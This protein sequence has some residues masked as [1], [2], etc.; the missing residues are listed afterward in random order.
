MSEVLEGMSEVLEGM[1]EALVECA[2]GNEHYVHCIGVS[3]SRSSTLR[4]Q[5]QQCPS[6]SPRCHWS[7]QRQRNSSPGKTS[8]PT[9]C[10]TI[11]YSSKDQ[12]VGC[13]NSE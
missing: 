3:R 13:G 11:G 10:V 8:S 2:Q 7:C 12:G 1:S 5:K 9:L 6:Q 4:A